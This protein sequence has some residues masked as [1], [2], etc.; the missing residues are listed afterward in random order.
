[1]ANRRKNMGDTMLTWSTRFLL[2]WLTLWGFL[3]YTQT[4]WMMWR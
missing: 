4:E 1:M 2:V 3:A